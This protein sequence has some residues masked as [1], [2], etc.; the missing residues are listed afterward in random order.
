MLPTKFKND[1]EC[2]SDTPKV[3][4]FGVWHENCKC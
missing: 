1:D 4:H 2:M 3:I